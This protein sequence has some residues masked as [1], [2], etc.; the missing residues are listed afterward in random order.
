MQSVAPSSGA[1]LMMSGSFSGS[2]SITVGL[3]LP[4]VVLQNSALR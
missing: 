4:R 2:A 1:A 3:L